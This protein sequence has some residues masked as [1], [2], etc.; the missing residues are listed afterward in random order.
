MSNF[1]VKNI[2]L[3][4]S[5]TPKSGAFKHVF[6]NYNDEEEDLTR[7]VNFQLDKVRVPFGVNYQ[8]YSGD[9]KATVPISLGKNQGKFL[10]FM[11]DFE[12]LVLREAKVRSE[13]WFGIQLNDDQ[14]SGM[15]KRS[16]YHKNKD[17]PPSLT[18]KVPSGVIVCDESNNVMKLSAIER[19]QYVNVKVE[20]G[21]IWISNNKFGVSWKV[22]HLTGLK[23]KPPK[24]NNNGKGKIEGYAF[25][26]DDE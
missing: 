18:P 17:Y 19:G 16:L 5:K 1:D 6:V 20:I 3:N 26:D 25:Q 11:R 22:T 14:L 24:N 8:E 10:K 23:Y 15:F 21:G 13:H 2:I 12:D 4:D 7:N 9:V